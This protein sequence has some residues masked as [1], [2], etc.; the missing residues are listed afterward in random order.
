MRILEVP[1]DN[2]G[3][4]SALTRASALYDARQVALVSYLNIDCLRLA[5]RNAEYRAV[6]QSAAMV[7][8]DG[9]GI[10]LATQFTGARKAAHW[11]VTDLFVT[12]IEQLAHRRAR[13]Y[14]LGGPEGVAEAAADLLR[15]ELP[16][17]AIVGCQNGYFYDDA[18]VIEAINASG[19]DVLIVGMGAPRQ[20]LWLQ[21][22]QAALKP[23]LRLAVGALF[24]W[25]SGQQPRAPAWVQTLH[26]EWFWRVLLE[27]GRLFRRYFLEDLP[28]LI[29]LPLKGVKAVPGTAERP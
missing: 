17:I 13:F 19:A 8:P 4:D 11:I 2:L 5:T 3:F 16:G 6:L 24:T 12:L 28:F 26:L 27:P 10:K 1:Y 9:I 21:R 25:V 22:H 15:H 29:S 7:L 14:F 18:A 20:E 23:T